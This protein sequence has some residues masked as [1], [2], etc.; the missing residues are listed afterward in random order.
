M[1]LERAFYTSSIV[2]N[3]I[4][5]KF[6]KKFTIYLFVFFVAFQQYPSKNCL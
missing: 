6:V 3:L 1:P 4:F 2:I 5:E